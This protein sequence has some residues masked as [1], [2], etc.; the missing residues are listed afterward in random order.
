[1]RGPQPHILRDQDMLAQLD[2]LG[3]C[4]G[5]NLVGDVGEL[6]CLLELAFPG[7]CV[8]QQGLAKGLVQLVGLLMLVVPFDYGHSALEHFW[9]W[10]AVKVRLFC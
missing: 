10:I 8:H 5:T 2:I 7:C 9:G 4:L 1:M 6:G 3:H